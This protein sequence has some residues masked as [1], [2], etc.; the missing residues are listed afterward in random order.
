MD[1][2]EAIVSA[3]WES[4]DQTAVNSLVGSA[5]KRSKFDGTWISIAGADV[6]TTSDRVRWPVATRSAK[7]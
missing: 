2:T 1:E 4:S 5:V 6:A 7:P 3:I